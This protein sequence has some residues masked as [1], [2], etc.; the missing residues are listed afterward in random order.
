[1]E[2]PG[3]LPGGDAVLCC[4]MGNRAI[5][6]GEFRSETTPQKIPRLGW[7]RPNLP[8][9]IESGLQRTIWPPLGRSPPLLSDARRTQCGTLGGLLFGFSSE[10][11]SVNMAP[12]RRG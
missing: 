1:M 9:P 12:A 8:G 4:W 3:S 2:L 7:A 6:P 10:L 11:G 5:L